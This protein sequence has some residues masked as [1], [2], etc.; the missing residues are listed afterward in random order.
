MPPQSPQSPHNLSRALS[1]YLQLDSLERAARAEDRAEEVVPF[2]LR[3]PRRRRSRNEEQEQRGLFRDEISSLRRVVHLRAVHRVKD[4][5]HGHAVLEQR[6]VL[7]EVINVD[8]LRV[9]EAL[10]HDAD[11]CALALLDLDQLLGARRRRR[12]PSLGGVAATAA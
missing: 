4:I 12:D 2:T 11:L 9:T 10:E 6:R 5:A 8:L 3:L 7:I 1:D